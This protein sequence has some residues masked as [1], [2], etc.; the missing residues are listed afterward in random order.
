[1]SSATE[2]GDGNAHYGTHSSESSLAARVLGAAY[3]LTSF[4]VAQFDPA[5]TWLPQYRYD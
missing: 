2:E 5:G 1:M 3:I 4:Y